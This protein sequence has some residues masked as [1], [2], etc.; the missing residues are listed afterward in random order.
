MAAAESKSTEQLSVI[1]FG[2]TGDLARKKLYP[3]LGALMRDGRIPESVNIVGYGRRAKVLEDLLA[4]QC[5]NVKGTAEQQAALKARCSY[6]KGGYGDAAAFEA[7][8]TQLETLAADQGADNRIFFL[9][10]PPFVFGD[11]C[12]CIK[13]KCESKNG[14]TRVMIEKPFGRDSK[15]FGE[16]NEITSSRFKEEQLFRI[17]HYLGKEVVMNL[18]TLRFANQIFAPMWN[19]QN[20][21]SIHVNW[22]EN[23]G[24]G[25]RGGYFDK[26]GIIRD[27]LQN[28]LLQVLMF[29][30]IE[31]PASFSGPAIAAA[32]CALLKS[33]KTLSPDD[34]VLGQFTKSMFKEFGEDKVEPGYLDDETVPEGSRC[35]TYAMLK[36]VIDNERWKGVPII[37]SAG[38]GLDERLCEVRIKFKPRQSTLFPQDAA[39][40]NELV[41]RIQPDE[42]IYFKVMTKEPGITIKPVP[43][44]LD[45]SYAKQFKGKKFGD[46]YELCYFECF[47][48]NNALFVGSDELVEA[49]RIF[50][51]LLH[52]IDEARPLPVGYPFGSTAPP[53]AHQ[54]A[55]K[56]G[57]PIRESWQEFIS[58][59]GADCDKLKALFTQC[60]KDQD[61]MLEKAEVKALLTSFYD[62]REPTDKLVGEVFRR[63]D[64]DN[65]GKITFDEL[66][67]NAP[68]LVAWTAT[69]ANKPAAEII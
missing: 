12:K 23:L 28:H 50:T 36:L 33:I 27:I 18:L 52:H 34:V 62:G 10:V 6:F 48:G 13:E 37:M 51:P 56:N 2:C 20:I 40:T 24:T 65:D 53:G 47:R 25:G 59:H 26:F 3:A 19:N 14:F 15:S 68:K 55:A 66:L 54:F 60:D 69:S 38:K 42:A 4:K 11:V 16:L 1:I 29:C 43:T 45:L 17:D 64:S 44:V 31:E 7:L 35:P 32:K 30:T 21:A 46:A 67:T 61:G 5:V 9:S 22:K 57:V 39:S 8:N 49:W 63:L 41:L 58:L